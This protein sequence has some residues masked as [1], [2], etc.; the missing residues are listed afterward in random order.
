MFQIEQAFPAQSTIPIKDDEKMEAFYRLVRLER[1]LAGAWFQLLR[2]PQHSASQA[3]KAFE[4]VLSFVDKTLGDFGGP[5]FLGNEVTFIDCLF[6]PFMER[7]E[8]SVKYWNNIIIREKSRIREWFEAME[9]WE[10]YNRMRSDDLTHVLALPP[11]IGRCRFQGTRKAESLS[12]DRFRKLAILNDGSDG[13][14]ARLEACAALVR[15]HE[16]VLKDAMDGAGADEK[17][18]SLT[19]SVGFGFRAAAEVLL[20]PDHLEAMEEAVQKNIAEEYRSLVASAA[21]FER[22]RCCTPRDMCV[23]AAVQFYGSMNWLI[24]VLEKDP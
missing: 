22:Q 9:R 23:D 8:S 16:A 7:I 10:P 24:R 14:P 5:Y 4:E 6:A 11:Q 12:V 20:D 3:D 18:P 17:N 15:N 13:E 19:D 21:R 1:A 2:G